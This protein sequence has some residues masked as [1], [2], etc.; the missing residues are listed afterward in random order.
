M[1]GVGVA[2]QGNNQGRWRG[3][4]QRDGGGK[5]EYGGDRDDGVMSERWKK[6]NR[7]SAG[8]TTKQQSRV[9]VLRGGD[10]QGGERRKNIQV[11]LRGDGG[12]VDG[13]GG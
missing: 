5:E 7:R 12:V 3:D 4:A 6:R 9:E 10:R 1:A 13:G 2:E 11:E 8:K